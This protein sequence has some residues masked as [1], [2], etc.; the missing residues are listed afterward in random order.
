MCIHQFFIFSQCGHSFFAPAPLVSCRTAAVGKRHRPGISMQESKSR[1]RR[2]EIDAVPPGSEAC[3]PTAHPYRTILIHS[4]LC[5]HCEIERAQA[6]QAAEKILNVVTFVEGKWRVRYTAPSKQDLGSE[7]NGG[8]AQGHEL[9]V[10]GFVEREKREE[11]RSKQSSLMRQGSSLSG[12]E[13]TGS[14]SSAASWKTSHRHKGS[15]GKASVMSFMSRGSKG[16]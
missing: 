6:L 2:P 3:I 12:T 13:N 10:N 8:W 11:E 5:L 9:D 16:R 1:R 15:E 4:S 7:P 14:P